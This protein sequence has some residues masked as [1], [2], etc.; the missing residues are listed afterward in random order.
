MEQSE[1]VSF[2]DDDD[3]GE[4][5]LEDDVEMDDAKLFENGRVCDGEADS[6]IEN[7]SG[8]VGGGGD[9]VGG[10]EDTCNNGGGGDMRD[11]ATGEPRRKWK[12]RMKKCRGSPTFNITCINRLVSSPQ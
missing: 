6:V 10:S 1:C 9:G 2:D 7:G 12:K 5:T 11:N 3:A 8:I 4:E